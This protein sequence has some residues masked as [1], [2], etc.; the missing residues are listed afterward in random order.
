MR[1]LRRVWILQVGWRG[2]QSA[3]ECRWK[4]SSRSSMQEK[5][6]VRLPRNGASISPVVWV[7]AEKV[8]A[9]AGP[10]CRLAAVPWGAAGPWRAE[11][12]RQIHT[13]EEQL[14]L[15]QQELRQELSRGKSIM[16]I[17]RE[18]GRELRLPPRWMN[19]KDHQ[20]FLE[21]SAMQIGISVEELKTELSSGR[22]LLDIAEEY[23]VILS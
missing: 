10:V 21:R 17:A 3:L 9:I 16:D 22:R 23:G 1:L 8:T 15:S 13:I 6:L 14:G 19:D 12:M 18:H 5:H 20:L 11:E 7:V 2:W 4:S